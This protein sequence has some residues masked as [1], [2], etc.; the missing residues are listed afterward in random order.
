[1]HWIDILVIG[2]LLVSGVFAYMRGFVHEVLSIVGWVGAAFATIHGTPVLKH[3]T[4]QF[5]A[6]PFISA[7]VTGIVI[8]IGSLVILSI[9]TRQISRGVKE[10]ALGALDRALGFLFGLLRGAIIVSLAWIGYE[11]FVPPEEQPE[12]YLESRTLPMVKQ[13]ASALKSLIPESE[14]PVDPNAPLD[15]NDPN[16]D[17]NAPA[18]V[19]GDAKSAL[20]KAINPT[21]KTPGGSKADGYGRKERS[22]M[23]R[24]FETSQ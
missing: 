19:P 8:F 18:Q 17:P 20:E 16:Y 15:P 4:Q 2:T 22:E 10:S 1:M 21:V 6:D 23:D 3:F 12:T 7:L 24:L 14:E 13:G 5:I 9:I 11:W